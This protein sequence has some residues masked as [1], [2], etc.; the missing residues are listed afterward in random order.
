MSIND[1]STRT[2]HGRKRTRSSLPRAIIDHAHECGDDALA[3]ISTD[4]KSVVIADTRASI[5]E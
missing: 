1:A 4:A 3:N 2:N 5:E